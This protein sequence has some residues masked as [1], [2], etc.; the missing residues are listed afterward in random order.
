[1]FLFNLDFNILIMEETSSNNTSSLFPTDFVGEKEWFFLYLIAL[2]ET[3]QQ[4][5]VPTPILYKNLP[6]SQTTVSRRII[7][8]EQQGYL[9]RS[10]GIKGGTVSLT[11][12]AY[13]ALESVYLNLHL[14]F[15]EKERF[16]RFSG[17]LQSG[18][19]EGA[20]YIKHP[21]YLPQFY[22]KVGF[23]PY[24]GT[25]NLQIL[26]VYAKLIEQRLEHFQYVQIEGFTDKSR[27]Y[28]PVKCYLVHL[29]SEK[30]P[31]KRV[32]GAFLRI[33]RTSHKPFTLEFISEQYLREFFHVKDG[34]TIYFEF[35]R[36]SKEN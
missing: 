14:I 13:S 31:Q 32:E 11:Q 19:G 23:F 1:M 18:M 5:N 27:T 17:K 24:F 25:L 26:P 29:W 7:E 6:F 16:D 9:N 21:K 22:Q 33:Q 30:E 4:K 34:D 28:G 8:L 36:N 20:H 35:K 10:Y 2:Q 3:P 15:E 12:K